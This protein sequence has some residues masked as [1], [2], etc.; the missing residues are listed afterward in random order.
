M[1]DLSDDVIYDIAV[2]AEDVA[3]YSEFVQA[4]DLWL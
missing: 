3:L 4:S 1:N 2:Y